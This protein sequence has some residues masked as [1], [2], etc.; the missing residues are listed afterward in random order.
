MSLL[1][2]NFCPVQLFFFR[3]KIFFNL[4]FLEYWE[5]FCGTLRL[6]SSSLYASITLFDVSQSSEYSRV[7]LKSAIKTHFSLKRN[8]KKWMNSNLEIWQEKIIKSSSRHPAYVLPNTSSVQTGD[9]SF[10]NMRNLSEFLNPG[11]R[12]IRKRKRHIHYCF[13]SNILFFLFSVL[14]ILYIY[15]QLSFRSFCSF[16]ME[17]HQSYGLKQRTNS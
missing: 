12:E 17:N 8:L 14:H 9:P 4:N 6:R 2:A 5:L 11:K 7:S 13:T 1:S 10:R 16:L 15:C 3:D